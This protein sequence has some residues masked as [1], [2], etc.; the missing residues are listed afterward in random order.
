M[1]QLWQGAQAAKAAKLPNGSV[2]S[3][4]PV[5]ENNAG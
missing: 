4:S 2:T 1:V 5:S 3:V